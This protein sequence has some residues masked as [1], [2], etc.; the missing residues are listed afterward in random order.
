MRTDTDWGVKSKMV[1]QVGKDGAILGRIDRCGCSRRV[2]TDTFAHGGGMS[3]AVA[4][5]DM[6]ECAP[7]EQQVGRVGLHVDIAGATAGCICAAAA[8]VDSLTPTIP[9]RSAEENTL[10]IPTLDVC[11]W[12][13]LSPRPALILGP[14]PFLSTK[15][16]PTA[17]RE[18]DA[19]HQPRAPHTL[20]SPIGDYL[21]HCI[22]YSS[23]I[24]PGRPTL[25][26]A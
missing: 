6:A 13:H 15:A 7:V 18:H 16:Q 20:R 4:S 25:A 10:S 19:F 12:V 24:P 8:H 3:E 5:V 11:A 23:A 14:A 1:G 22:P 9:A 17:H 26:P 21:Y 2:H